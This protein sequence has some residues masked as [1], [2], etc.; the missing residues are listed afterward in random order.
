VCVY[1]ASSSV[2]DAVFVDCARR[3]GV[4]LAT[5]GHTLVYGAG[6]IGLMGAL[7]QAV[8]GTGGKV[9]GVIP[10]KLRGLEVCYE[11]ADELI[12]TKTMRERKA[13]ME[14][15]ADGF[16]VLPG[17]IGTL[18][19]VLEVL[20]LRQLHYHNKPIVFLN[21]DGYYDDLLTFFRHMVET[22][23]LLHSLDKLIHVA[24]LPEDAI[25]YL[26]TYEPPL[27]DSITAK[28]FPEDK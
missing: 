22:R 24:K 21:I 9:I 6:N 8:H 27:Q 10:E 12:V 18:E 15:R 26:D 4:L 5:H 17:G 11:E 7:A 25:A 2:V 16:V 13:I 28:L 1:A 3:L 14:E 19:E 20:V 23:F